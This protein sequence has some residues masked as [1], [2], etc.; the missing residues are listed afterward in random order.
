MYCW[1]SKKGATLVK[2]NTIA[3]LDTTRSQAEQ[4]L[5]DDLHHHYT[6]LLIVADSRWSALTALIAESNG[7]MT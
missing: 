2:N 7:H 5:G 1:C 4:L 3:H 6:F